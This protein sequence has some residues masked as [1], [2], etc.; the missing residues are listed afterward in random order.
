MFFQIGF[1]KCGTTA[2]WDFFNRNGIPAIH[3]D[4][5]NLARRMRANLEAGRRILDGYDER[6][7]CFT[8]M[9]FNDPDDYFERFKCYR[10]IMR[11]Y[12]G[13]KFIINTRSQERWLRSMRRWARRTRRSRYL[14]YRYGS[15]SLRRFSAELRHDWDAHYRDVLATI[16]SSQLLVF[17][18]AR[19]APEV[20]CTFCDLPVSA[21]A[22]YLKQNISPDGLTHWAGR[23][24]PRVVTR[25]LRLGFW[26]LFPRYWNR[27][28]RQ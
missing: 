20:L 27:S 9:E 25:M 7:S 8:D 21:A 4:A 5:G 15:A 24:L 19:D 17:D 6:Y 18:I 11:D 13:A 14:K 10:E 1:R 23:N 16:P 28:R 22:H 2:L 26:W 12:P 3:W